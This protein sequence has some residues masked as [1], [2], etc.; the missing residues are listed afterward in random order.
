L[1]AVAVKIYITPEIVTSF[2]CIR[3]KKG[4]IFIFTESSTFPMFT[5]VISTLHDRTP[6]SQLLLLTVRSRDIIILSVFFIY[7][8][9]NVWGCYMCEN[10]T[11]E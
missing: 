7:L 3:L 5:W 10:C 9:L 11:H 6:W 1:K 4:H 8:V 2:T